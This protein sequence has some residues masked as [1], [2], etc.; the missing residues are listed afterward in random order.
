MKVKVGITNLETRSGNCAAINRIGEA[1]KGYGDSSILSRARGLQNISVLVFTLLN[2][3]KCGKCFMGKYDSN[4][5]K[6]KVEYLA[7]AQTTPDSLTENY[8]ICPSRPLVWSDF[9]GSV[10]SDCVIH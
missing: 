3:S 10:C 1:R 6:P 4:L 8:V 5:I 2:F 9:L 7:F